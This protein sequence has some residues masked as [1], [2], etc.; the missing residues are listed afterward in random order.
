MVCVAADPAAA[1][2]PT[3]LDEVAALLQHDRPIDLRILVADAS[4]PRAQSDEDALATLCRGLPDAVIVRDR[5]GQL[6]R[7]LGATS[8]GYAWVYAPIATLAVA[9]SLIGTDGRPNP[10]TIRRMRHVLRLQPR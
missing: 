2:L 3:T 8:A 1:H 9:A 4:G 6:A 5:D 7:S 10:E